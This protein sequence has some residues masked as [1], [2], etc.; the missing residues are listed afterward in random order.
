MIIGALEPLREKG[1]ITYEVVQTAEGLI[2]AGINGLKEDNAGGS[3]WYR[4]NGQNILE[5]VDEY[6]LNDGDLILFYRSKHP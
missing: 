3:W 1:S 5:D 4:V 6:E 2:L